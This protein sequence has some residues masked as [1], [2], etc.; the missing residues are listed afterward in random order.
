MTKRAALG[1]FFH[2]TFIRVALGSDFQN[3][4]LRYVDK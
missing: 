3:A 2:Q 1:K 4:C